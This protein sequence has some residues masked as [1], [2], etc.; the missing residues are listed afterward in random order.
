M[1]PSSAAIA[2]LRIVPAAYL[3]ACMLTLLALQADQIADPIRAINQF[4]PGSGRLAAR[5]SY[6]SHLVTHHS[7]VHL[8]AV[9]IWAI[10]IC[11]AGRAILR[12]ET[13]SAIFFC[14]STTAILLGILG[15]HSASLAIRI[16]ALGPVAGPILF[17]IFIAVALIFIIAAAVTAERSE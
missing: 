5:T 9:L 12:M 13:G 8:Y 11:R 7:L 17:P 1:K 4:I 3:G 16:Y 10:Y 2:H 15:S 6:P 14:L